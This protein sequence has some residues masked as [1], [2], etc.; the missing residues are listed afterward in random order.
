MCVVSVMTFVLQQREGSPCVC[1]ANRE[2][3]KKMRSWSMMLC[4]FVCVP[5]KA[6]VG[7]VINNVAGG[8]GVTP[9]I[10]PVCLLNFFS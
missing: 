6:S 10:V 3:V 9:E 4:V 7:N 5:L 8:G 2:N 1:F